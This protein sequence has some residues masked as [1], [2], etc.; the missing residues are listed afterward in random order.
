MT[1][2]SRHGMPALSEDLRRW[3]L[4][5]LP[6]SDVPSRSDWHAVSCAFG[7]LLEVL[8]GWFA[9]GLVAASA[10]IAGFLV[11]WFAPWWLS[12]GLAA[13]GLFAVALWR[14]DRRGDRDA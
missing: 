13:A 8:A 11:V 5:L 3:L 9:I 14:L 1:Q 6:D 4:W 10:A 12:A 7:D 2:H